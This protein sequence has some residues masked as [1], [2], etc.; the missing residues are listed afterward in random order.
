MYPQFLIDSLLGQYSFKGIPGGSI[1]KESACSARYLGSIPGLGSS[2]G[3]GNDYPRQYSC[4]ENTMDIGTLQATVHGVTESD[5]TELLIHQT[6][7]LKG[8]VIP[9]SSHQSLLFQ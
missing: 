5:T 6:I 2:P 7:L 8:K 9:E 3:E 1:G 4:L